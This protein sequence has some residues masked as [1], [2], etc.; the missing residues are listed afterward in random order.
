MLVPGR[1]CLAI[2]TII[3]TT[4]LAAEI[5]EAD[6]ILLNGKIITVDAQDTISQAVAIKG[7]KILKVGDDQE[8]MALAGPQCQIIELEN[9]T[10]TPGLVDSHYHL[11]YYGQQF[12]PG[13][14]NIRHPE[15]SSKA[16]LLRVVAD[17]A[18][19]L[20]EGEWISGNQGFH[21]LPDETVDRWDLD[22][23]APNNPVYLRHGGGQHSVANSLALEI[24][25]IDA[26]TPNPHSSMIFHD[27]QG[28]PTGVLSHY[29]AENLV[30]RHATG[31]GDR[32]QEQKFEDIERGQELCLQAGYTSIQDVIVGSP[33]DVMVYKKFAESG[34]L[35]V[36]VYLM[37]YLST[38]EQA[39]FAAQIC[40]CFES[41][42]LKFGGWKLAV[43]GG[44]AAK[45]ILMY[46]KSLYASSLSYPYHSQETLNRIVQILHDT[47]LQIAVHV[48]GD[49]GI[50]MTL[51]AFEEAMKVNPR[52]DP[53][54]RIEH[55]LLP[56]PDALRRMKE[57]NVVLSTQ[58]QWI[59]WHGDGYQQATNDEAM[60]HLLP[61]NTMLQMGIPLAFGC[62]VPASIYQEPKWAFAGA[63]LRRTRTGAVLTPE[64]CLTMQE[65]LRIHTMGSAYASFSETTTGSLEP[66]KYADL[67]VWSHD[68]YEIPPKEINNLEVEMT[69]FNGEIVY[70]AG[71]IQ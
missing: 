51:T 28:E 35:R 52:P 36:R 21:L 41:D 45:T 2:V 50:D 66:G 61:L 4:S 16:D 39:D 68:I 58:P 57:A 11:M 40:E 56:S 43:D 7:S 55:G 19:Q 24:A 30:G 69:I 25:G 70:D 14:L 34:R 20:D 47:G 13:Y 71:R 9:N 42:M 60:N 26:N 38:L 31:Y 67:V 12:W 62:D 3:S 48:V 18:R 59:A 29:P 37:L 54:H 32:T 63:S 17:R 22:A 5:E 8:I 10:V 15:V 44:F 6:L 65:V 23:A 64:E 46:D 49:Q 53:R 27:D 1:L 33:A